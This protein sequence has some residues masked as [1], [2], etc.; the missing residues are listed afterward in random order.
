MFRKEE[1]A[2]EIW[3]KPQATNQTSGIE[4]LCDSMEGG[5][6]F[7]TGHFG[8]SV[9]SLAYPPSCKSSATPLKLFLS[10]K[11]RLFVANTTV[12][13]ACTVHLN[14]DAFVVH[15]ASS[16]PHMLVLSVCSS[17]RVP[18]DLIDLLIVP[19]ETLEHGHEADDSGH[20]SPR[21]CWKPNPPR[22]YTTGRCETPGGLHGSEKIICQ[23]FGRKLLGDPIVFHAVSR[24]AIQDFDHLEHQAIVIPA[25]DVGFLVAGTCQPPRTEFCTPEETLDELDH[26]SLPTASC[27]FRT[28]HLSSSQPHGADFGEVPGREGVP[29]FSHA[30]QIDISHRGGVT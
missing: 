19:S 7:A 6:R 15:E 3:K 5:R 9:T 28:R 24:P 14:D 22:R 26:L 8:V 1:G 23:K 29:T 30:V 4:L 27:E 13:F 25:I 20:H 12:E 2:R 16:P 10:P 18:A 21:T 11:R 17:S